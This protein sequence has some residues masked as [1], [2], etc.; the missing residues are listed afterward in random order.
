MLLDV[1]LERLEEA[2]DEELGHP[3]EHPLADAGHDPADL[4][5]AIVIVVSRKRELSLAADYLC[6]NLSVKTAF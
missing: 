5:G 1:F 2:L 4:S 6:I 3:A